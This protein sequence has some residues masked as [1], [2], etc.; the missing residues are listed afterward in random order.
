MFFDAGV[1]D[2]LRVVAGVPM[3]EREGRIPPEV[4]FCSPE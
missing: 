3:V 4:A 1:P 2:E